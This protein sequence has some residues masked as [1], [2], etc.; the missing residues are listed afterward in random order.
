[1]NQDGRK[2][3]YIF[4]VTPVIDGGRF[5]I[6]RIVGEELTVEADLVADG[7]DVV[8]GRLGWRILPNRPWSYVPLQ[9]LDN[10]RYRAVFPLTEIG[11]YEYRIE[12]WVDEFLTWRYRLVKKWALGQDIDAEL[13]MGR[14]LIWQRIALYAKGPKS[15][16]DEV[17][18]A[19]ETL[20]RLLHR[21][22]ETSEKEQRLL[23]MQ[24]PQLEQMMRKL[25]DLQHAGQSRRFPVRV[26]RIR[27]GFSAWYEFFPRSCPTRKNG[28]GTLRDCEEFLPYIADLGFD[29]VYLPP[30]HPIG[31]QHRKGA[32]N[33]TVA[34]PDDPGSPWAIGNEEGGHMAIHPQL[35]TLTDFDHFHQTLRALGLELAMDL[36]FQCSPDHPWVKEHPQWFRHFPDGTIQYAENPPKKYEDVF[37]LNFDTPDWQ[38]LWNALLDITQFWAERGVRIFRVDNPHTKPLVFWEWFITQMQ[39]RFPD[40]IFLSE[41]FTRPK[42][43]EALSKVGFTQS[44]TYFAWRNTAQELRDYVSELFFTEKNQYFR[45]NF[46]PNTPDILPGFLQTDR[47]AAFTVR[48]ILA[49]T[50]SPNYGIYG[51]AYELLE[52]QPLSWGS[53]EYDHSEKYEIRHWNLSQQPNIQDVIKKVNAIRHQELALQH[54]GILT[55]HHVDNPQLLVYSKRD[56]AYHSRLLMV[57]NL[58][59]VFTQSG[60]TALDMNALGLH[61]DAHYVV[62]DLLTGAR[63]AW[64]GP[65]NYVELHPDGYNA[66]ILRIEEG[67]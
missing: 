49:A 66:H 30:I 20:R 7:H 37:P 48:F 28:H 34:S 53:E 65:Y 67:I 60:W 15:K 33:Q 6:K 59:P 10:D 50:L 29:V 32:N 1:M 57:V 13:L 16:S 64:N 22:D 5:P 23:L 56:P 61:E 35:G 24:D 43:M 25:P 9:P 31:L 58:D 17:V 51:P 39:S 44:Y 55:F 38:D 18:E 14:E 21:F 45:P 36:T 26:D 19:L 42:L 12:G 54:N 52:H 63:Y 47:P 40:T 41:A 11:L 27:A 4:H 2:R 3:V 46:W 8:Q 62:H